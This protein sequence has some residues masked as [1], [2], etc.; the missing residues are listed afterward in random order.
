MTTRAPN[1]MFLKFNKLWRLNMRLRRVMFIFLELVSVSGS[2]ES[3]VQ[4]LLI[5]Q[6]IRK[7]LKNSFEKFEAMMLIFFLIFWSKALCFILFFN[8]FLKIWF[9]SWICY[10]V[11]VSCEWKLIVKNVIKLS[12]LQ[13]IFL[14]YFSQYEFFFFKGL[15]Y[16]IS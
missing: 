14:L 6:W 5:F 4:L 11:R 7:L 1:W 8:L 3:I 12:P 10:K 13:T 2:F 16:I 15:Q 9:H